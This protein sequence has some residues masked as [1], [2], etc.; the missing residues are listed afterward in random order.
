MNIRINIILMLL[1]F[2]F[3][4]QGANAIDVVMMQE[5]GGVRS[6][7]VYNSIITSVAPNNSTSVVLCS[8]PPDCNGSYICDAIQK[9][10]VLGQGPVA[11]SCDKTV[12]GSPVG[13]NLLC[14][15]GSQCDTGDPNATWR[16]D[17]L[18]SSF[19][20]GRLSVLKIIVVN[21]TE[22]L[23]NVTSQGQDPPGEVIS[24]LEW[25]IEGYKLNITG[26]G[27]AD[28]TVNLYDNY[29]NL[30]KTTQTDA[31][32]FY[33]FCELAPG[34]Y[35]VCE[36]LKAGWIN[37]TN[38]CLPVSLYSDDSKNNNF[39]NRLRTGSNESP[40]YNGSSEWCIGSYELSASGGGVA[41]VDLVKS[42]KTDSS[43]LY[44]FCNLS[45]GGYKVC[46]G[47]KSGWINL[48]DTCIPVTLSRD[49]SKDNNFTNLALA[50]GS[51]LCIEGYK[52]NITGEGLADWMVRLNEKVGN[53]IKITTTNASGF[54]SFCSLPAG[55][56]TVCEELKGGWINL[57]EA[58][59]PVR[60]DRNSSK[61]NN[62][63]NAPLISG[64]GSDLCIEG[65]KLSNITGEGLANWTVSLY[66]SNG[67]A[68]RT[69]I[70]DSSGS[71]S[72][73]SLPAGN[74]T[75]CEELKG[76]WINL[77]EACI[78][79]RLDGNSSK[80]SNFTNAPL[81]SAQDSELCIEGYKR[82][83]V[84]GEGLENWTVYLIKAAKSDAIGWC[85]Y[86]D[87]FTKAA[88]GSAMGLGGPM[89]A[90]PKLGIATFKLPEPGYLI[91]WTNGSCGVVPANQVLVIVNS[92]LGFKESG[93]IAS[94]LAG[95]LNGSVVGEFQYLNL[96][97]I[98]IQSRTRDELLR[99]IAYARNYDSIDLAFPNYP[100][101]HEYSS[102]LDDEVY[103]GESGKAYRIIGLNESWD[104]I[105]TSGIPISETQLGVTDDGLYPG[106]G[107]FDRPDI[108]TSMKICPEAPSSLLDAPLPDFEIAGSHG[109]GI[110]NILVAD[111]DDGGLVGIL[112]PAMSTGKEIKFDMIN[113][114]IEDRAF[115]TTSLLGLK[116]EI[117]NG[118]TI[119]S[120][121][122][123]NSDADEQATIMYE[124]FFKKLLD[125]YPNLLFVFSAGNDG[126]EL[127]GKIRIPNGL[128]H[129]SLPNL[130]TVGNI[131]ND[132]RI[133]D[134]SNRNQD[135]EYVTL[136]APGEQAVWGRDNL[137]R[138]VN[139]WGGTSMA[140]PQVSA[141]AALVRSINPG[142][143]AG[144]IKNILIETGR[145]DIDGI[146][147]PKELG[148]RVIAVDNAVRKAL[149]ER[150][151]EVETGTN[152]RPNI[153]LP[154]GYD[155]NTNII[156]STDSSYDESSEFEAT[157]AI[158]SIQYQGYD[159]MVDG[160]L[161]GTEGT[162][163]DPLDGSYVFKVLG[164]KRHVIRVDHPLNW[165]R[166]L[167]FFKGGD[168]YSYN[169]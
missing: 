61:D 14:D 121:S 100:L 123:G 25:C 7:Y 135:N 69:T 115:I 128:P 74:Y 34:D 148:G 56:Y 104:L 136:A 42:A 80:D 16:C 44:S 66:D 22:L 147:I 86:C 119:F 168:N 111:D 63:T 21:S 164:N 84:A 81:E 105:K 158:K 78:P 50:D 95:D 85:P 65:Y 88:L 122:W 82:N 112:T 93:I 28:W 144:E 129:G 9:I 72:F 64:G 91:N 102:P 35:T 92:S 157:V 27:L 30:I 58:C 132:G 52:L 10:S 36:E 33:S 62:F 13:G 57:T 137:G 32:G 60:L 70:T 138:T 169:F 29:G 46:E 108:N 131:M 154:E 165:K 110:F 41:S 150:S 151:V 134:S 4:A 77:T 6:Y 31:S 40:E 37:V 167:G 162:G 159:V 71:Y 79:V 43:G 97:Q 109:T 47:A 99:D 8:P 145:Q 161:I 106:Y 118:C 83:G 39:I 23:P 2:A 17:S 116:A 101:C 75:V 48:S 90:V 166:W 113:I 54:Y 18:D 73:C 1:S 153:E 152:I 67:A 11:V 89:A 142:L 126:I 155:L 127:D 55:N 141:A 107:E 163:L 160:K 140:T 45:P 130:I 49:G 149:D 3:I 114:F 59:I 143:N 133:C 96:F 94:R 20:C 76:G 103:Q 117:E 124:R 51:D 12:Y 68:I 139:E 120:N 24:R 98:E 38:I 53:A 19:P 26:E 156:G 15:M 5:Y 87:K 146:A 125:D